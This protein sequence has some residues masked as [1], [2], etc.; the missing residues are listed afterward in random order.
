MEIVKNAASPTDASEIELSAGFD[1]EFRNLKFSV[2]GKEIL[3]GINGHC[4][5][6]RILAILGQSGA[7]KSTVRRN[8]PSS[9][10]ILNK[11]FC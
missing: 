9:S 8:E 2:P 11:V 5:A 3:K 10:R 1:I 4:K 7:G 6:G